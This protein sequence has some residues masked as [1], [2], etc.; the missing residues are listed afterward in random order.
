MSVSVLVRGNVPRWMTTIENFFS[1][2]DI[3][4]LLDTVKRGAVQS[5]D[6][7]FDI[8]VWELYFRTSYEDGLFG[9]GAAK[10]ERI[11]RR[12]S[13]PYLRRLEKIQAELP[14]G[15]TMRIED[16]ISEERG[17]SR[18]EL[19]FVV[20][21][22]VTAEYSKAC[23]SE[24]NEGNI[25]HDWNM[26]A[27]FI[28]SAREFKDRIMTSRSDVVQTIKERSGKEYGLEVAFY[29]DHYCKDF[30]GFDDDSTFYKSHGMVNLCGL[31][32]CYGLAWAV[33]SLSAHTTR[34]ILTI[35][36][37]D[38]LGLFSNQRGGIG[39]GK[40]KVARLEIVPQ[41][42]EPPKYAEW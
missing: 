21:A 40:I 19:L 10:A 34:C 3:Q 17:R 39:K 2:A 5:Y 14:R 26:P 35:V 28:N 37:D 23:Y 11:M 20:Y 22:S 16:K 7:S 41:K 42:P 38:P 13:K 30:F 25:V 31:E 4:Y 9:G 32:Q 27:T 1:T 12:E 15:I 36:D 8:R 29:E 6:Q 33:A 18:L 24:I